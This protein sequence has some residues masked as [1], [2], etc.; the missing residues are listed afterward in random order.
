M[1]APSHTYMMLMH[2]SE[3]GEFCYV[4]YI[5]MLCFVVPV[6]KYLKLLN[7]DHLGGRIILEWILER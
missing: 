1:N 2:I 6:Q 5:K 4:I 3:L 7:R